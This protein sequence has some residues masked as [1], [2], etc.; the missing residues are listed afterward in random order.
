M[1]RLTQHFTLEELTHSQ[2]AARKRLGNTPDQ[3]SEARKN[4]QRLAETLE[5]VRTILG[6]NPIMVSSGYRSAPVNAAVG[7]SVASRHMHGLACDFTCPG[8]GTSLEICK[9]LEPHMREL[10]IDQ[11]IYEFGAW[12]HLGLTN[13]KPRHQK[14]T[15][16]TGGTRGGFG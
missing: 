12:V 13:G 15:I 3:D 9:A 10:A 5:E 7:G 8:F 11:L 2:T 14:L 16:D 4:L 6:D 1:V